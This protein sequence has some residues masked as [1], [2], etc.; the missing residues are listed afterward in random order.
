MKGDSVVVNGRI[1]RFLVW[2]TGALPRSLSRWVSGMA[3]RQ[4]SQDVNVGEARP[5][6]RFVVSG[7]AETLL[8][9]IRYALR[10]MRAQPG[11][12]GRRDPL[13]R[14]RRRRQHRDVLAGRLAAVPAAA[15]QHRPTRW[16]TSSPPAATATSTPPPPTRLPRSQGAEHRLH[17]HDRLQPDDGAAQPR[18]SI[19]HRARA[20]SS[21]RIISRCSACSRSS[22]ACCV[23][24][25]DEPGARARG[26]DLAS[27]VAARVRRRSRRSSASRSRCAACRTP[28]PAS[29]RQ[30]FTGVVPLLTPELWLPIAHVEEVEPAGINDSV[31]SPIGTHAARAARHALDVRQG[32][33]EAGR[34]RRAGARQRRADRAPARGRAS[35]D[36]QGSADVGRADR[37]R[38]AARAAG[39]RRPVDRRGRA[40]GGR[41]PRAADCLRERRRHAAGARLGA[42]PRDQRAAGHRRQPRRG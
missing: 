10:W 30:S 9:D 31:P 8:K 38:A 29:R 28:S 6:T 16:S 37:G 41:R 35:A 26:G 14:P 5:S 25:D 39:R 12:F 13:A 4:I 15:G 21:R 34:H 42:T 24:S 22:A 40:D 17:R 32:P 11:I 36:Q 18:R 23:P 1:Y 19:A 2:L 33:A 20:R 27:H 3:G 7:M